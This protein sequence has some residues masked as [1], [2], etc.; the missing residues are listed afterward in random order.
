MN[1]WL[2]SQ[3]RKL[4]QVPDIFTPDG[5]VTAQLIVQAVKAADGD[6]VD[7]MIAGLENYKFTGPKGPQ[8]IRPA[9]HA[10]IQPMFKVELVKQKNGRYDV[11]VL[12]T[13]SPGNV[14]PPITKKF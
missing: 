8:R 4:G 14:Q 11:K 10:M 9:D 13:V 12:G 2:V 7:K 3:M 5:F 1:T 6:D